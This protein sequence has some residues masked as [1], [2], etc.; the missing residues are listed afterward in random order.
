MAT[1]QN[2]E[3]TNARTRRNKRKAAQQQNASTK[4]NKSDCDGKK[5]KATSARTA[6][7]EIC[8]RSGDMVAGNSSKNA[9]QRSGANESGRKSRQSG[10]VQS[11]PRNAETK[12]LLTLLKGKKLSPAAMSEINAAISE[13]TEP[14]REN[15]TANRRRS[16]CEGEHEDEFF[17]EDRDRNL[18]TGEEN[19]EEV[20]ESDDEVV[21]GNINSQS[22]DEHDL[23]VNLE[24]PLPLDEEPDDAFH[25]DP[26]TS[27]VGEAAN[28]R[29]RDPD[30]PPVAEAG[31]NRI[32]M[33]PPIERT[34]HELSTESRRDVS[35]V[36][37]R[38][39]QPAS[40]INSNSGTVDE[41]V[42]HHIAE[43]MKECVTERVNKSVDSLSVKI[44]REL[45][46]VTKIRDQVADLTNVV[47]TVARAVFI[48]Q[49][50]ALPRV[51]EI[52][53]KICLL[54]ALFTESFILKVMAHCVLCSSWKH[55]NANRSM[56]SLERSGTELLS[57]LF[58]SR[59][60]TEKAKEK[61]SSETGRKFSRFRNGVMLSAFRAMQTNKFKIF[62]EGDEKNT[63][64]NL[65]APE[66]EESFAER[67]TSTNSIVRTLFQPFW[68]KPGYV[69]TEHCLAAAV[70][71]E[72]Q[73][74]TEG[75]EESQSMTDT[76]VSDGIDQNPSDTKQKVSRSGPITREEIS[77]EASCL[78]YKIIT[79]VLHRSRLTS[80]TELF[81]SA[82]YLFTGWAQFDTP[83]K[84]DTMKLKWEELTYPSTSFMKDL[85]KTKVLKETS[86]IRS[87]VIDVQQLDIDNL[88]ILE[89]L[90]SEHP[91]LCLLVEHEVI[92]EGRS[93]I[94]KYRISMIEVA[95]KFFASFIGT[96]PHAKAKNALNLDEN[97]VV[98]IMLI[99]VGLRRLLEKAVVDRNENN[100]VPWSKNII[101]KGKR[102]RPKKKVAGDSTSSVIPS[103]QY[104]FEM[105]EGLNVNSLQPPP[106]KQRDLLHHMILTVSKEEFLSRSQ[107]EVTLDRL[108]RS[109]S[110]G[111]GA[112]IQQD[113]CL[114]IFDVLQL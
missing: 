85:P 81:Q 97:A 55:K 53:N 34:D 107:Q 72:K 21:G 66:V 108:D 61:F 10:P 6:A 60:P 92:L 58:F 98:L 70:K 54:P 75:A 100:Y 67:G 12:Q 33:T 40:S 19:D 45:D 74:S 2:Q 63:M 113:E 15:D 104:A 77:I 78:V 9:N 29:N 4:K 57:I 41:S 50:S 49:P 96:E 71:Y 99:A 112:G 43:R 42:V 101:T 105:I 24:D 76:D 27:V 23:G 87:N 47:T 37:T 52:H 38:L 65:I 91:E 51:K 83:V 14:G 86:T 31:K 82:F 109:N 89:Q 30:I 114:G 62:R 80:K 20:E 88:R 102:G 59:Q 5:K 64:L 90:I 28:N 110:M 35:N 106:S 69:T 8:G 84:Q 36:D 93:S 25:Q 95:C 1:K 13:S 79:S 46:E 22:E 18:D 103:G 56:Q 3:E 32:S 94:L 26:V 68:L 17:D 111:I 44:C 16:V 7:G 11:K 73:P 39:I 48:K